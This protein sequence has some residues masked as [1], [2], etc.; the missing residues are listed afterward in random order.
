MSDVATQLR[1]MEGQVARAK[2]RLAP[3][4]SATLATRCCLLP[5]IAFAPGAQ[6]LMHDGR[7]RRRLLPGSPVSAF[8]LLLVLSC[9]QIVGIEDQPPGAGAGAGGTAD[10]GVE[11]SA[12]CGGFPW[13]PSTCAACVERACCAQAKAC[14]GDALCAT[15]FDCIAS[16]PGSDDACRSACVSPHEDNDTMAALASCQAASCAKECGLRCGGY[17]SYFGPP[18]PSPA[19]AGAQD[20][21]FACLESSSYCAALGAIASCPSCLAQEFCAQRCVGFYD[22]I[23]INDCAVA[24]PL[25]GAGADSG[26]LTVLNGACASVCPPGTHWDC[27]GHV[28]WPQETAPQVTFRLQVTSLNGATPIG[29]AQI[30]LCPLTDFNCDAPLSTQMILTDPNGVTSITLPA[31]FQGYFEIQAQGFVPELFLFTPTIAETMLPGTLQN[32]AMFP[33]G[34]FASYVMQVVPT[35]DTTTKGVLY[36]APVDCAGEGAPNVSFEADPT[37]LGSSAAP[38]YIVNG[39]TPDGKAVATSNAGQG[40]LIGGGWVQVDPGLLP[41]TAA[42]GGTHVAKQGAPIR[43]GALTVVQLVPTP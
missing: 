41:V 4:E 2:P 28:T 11:A 25:T 32:I 24:Y 13:S 9:R 31:P 33:S 8:V 36:V 30:R 39:M 26:L 27:V 18:L 19:D 38:Y 34:L 7:M 3:S 1:T 43:A 35:P 5:W 42:V 21:C 17:E 10:A 23:C 22:G 15:E 14:R 29:N 20:A 37:K 12:K 16:C 40:G 6:R